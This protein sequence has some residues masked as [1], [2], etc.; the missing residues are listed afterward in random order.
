MLY[1]NPVL[2]YKIWGSES[3][4]QSSQNKLINATM[5]AGPVSFLP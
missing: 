3:D 1:L 4:V 5:E 2:P